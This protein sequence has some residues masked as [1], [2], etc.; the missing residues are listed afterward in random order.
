[1]KLS[2]LPKENGSRARMVVITHGAE[3]TIVVD[4]KLIIIFYTLVYEVYL[5]C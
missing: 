5:N 2:A 1:M 4:S 3:P